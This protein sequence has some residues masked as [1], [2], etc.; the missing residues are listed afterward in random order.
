MCGIA[1]IATFRNNSIDRGT[2]ERMV[3]VL[4][5][6]GPDD[7]GV[8][9]SQEN[10]QANLK[11][12]LAHA[13]LSIIDVEGGHQPMSNEDKTIWIVY[14]GEIYNFP[15][16]KKG[17]LEKGHRFATKSDTEA[18]LHL[19]EEKGVDCLQDLRGMFAF[20]IWDARE[21]RLFLARD[22]VG[23]K[24]LYYLH[25]D[26]VFLFASE[27]KSLLEH[28]IVTRELD[29][30][31][32][33]SYLTYGYTPSPHTIFRGIK[34]LPPA[35]YAIYDKNGFKIRQYWKL[36]YKS[37]NSL[38]LTESKERLYELLSEATRMRLISDVPL[39]AFLSGGVDSSCIVALMSKTSSKK[40]KTFSIGF[41]E[42][43]FDELKYAR[44]ISERFGTKHKELIVK[45]KALDVL[46]KLAWHYDQPFGDSSC[47][48]TYYVSKMTRKYVT[49]A[50]NGDGGDE[51]FAGYERYKGVKLA[52]SLRYI[53]KGLLKIGHGAGYFSAYGR[54]FFGGL[55]RNRDIEGAYI[56]WLN[57]FDG[58]DK[59]AL[60]SDKIKSVLKESRADIYFRNIVSESDA[61]NPVEK[62][63]NTD[64][65]SYLPED[66]LIKI[67]IATMANSL[68]GRSPFLDHKVM[69][70]VATIPLEYKLKGLSS[71][72]ILKETFKE[73]IPLSFLNRKKRGFGVPVGRWFSNELKGFIRGMLL[74][75][76]SLK[77]NL[78]SREYIKKLLDEHQ[79][80]RRDHTHRLYALLSFEMWHRIFI[81]REML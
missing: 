54:R 30:E 59:K 24:P 75:E 43:D 50:L 51:L 74:G 37:K 62:I 66:L 28:R 4:R 81:D 14:N 76:R 80:G 67:D 71:K 41:D 46:P 69:E 38:S 21:E 48:P 47:I 70:F 7:E 53:P 6:R 72:Y 78:F 19:Y 44:F 60:Y 55:I 61:E 15:E 9:L 13:R 68:E 27:I 25:K 73:E 5:H 58:G 29:I 32:L 57:Y 22:R 11:V 40:V 23:Q 52:H 63:I 39:G 36:S 56:S 34:K 2:L 1:G 18:L 17:L 26:G 42:K 31:S 12:G 3:S 49:V 45:P 8:Y 65:R 77:K 79:R 64:I 10:P 35:H 16:L 33:D 20:C